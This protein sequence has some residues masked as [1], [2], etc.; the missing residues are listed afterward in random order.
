MGLPGTLTITV[1]QV[2]SPFSESGASFT[3]ANYD[4]ILIYNNNMYTN[5]SLGTN[6]NSFIA[7]GGSVI[8][9]TFSF[10]NNG[11][12]GFNFANSAYQIG[13]ANSTTAQTGFTATVAHPITSGVGTNFSFTATAYSSGNLALQSGATTIATAN[14][15]GFPLIGIKTVGSA[16]QVGINSYTDTS[17]SDTTGNFQKLVCR[18]I[19]WCRGII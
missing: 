13:T 5:T 11:L 16:R 1:L 6:L 15:S 18:A 17:F 14:T 7:N 12:P 19:Y 3:T 9:T 8:V 4:V 10:Q 2:P